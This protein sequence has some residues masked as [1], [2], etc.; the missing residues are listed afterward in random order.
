VATPSGGVLA[1]FSKKIRVINLPFLLSNQKVAYKVL[2][3]SA[4]GQ[5]LLDSLSETGLIGLAFGDYGMRNLTS[6][7]EIKNF[8]T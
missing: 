8:D 7:K 2:N 6:K 4:F 5:K 3:E 1:N